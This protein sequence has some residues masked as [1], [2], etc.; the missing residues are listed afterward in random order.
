MLFVG[1]RGAAGGL[2]FRKGKNKMNRLLSATVVCAAL[3]LLPYLRAETGEGA[4]A[5]EG[6][7]WTLSEGIL[8]KEGWQFPAE[9]LAAQK[10][11]YIAGYTA[12]QGVL[13]WDG[14]VLRMGKERAGSA[15]SSVEGME[16]A[17][18]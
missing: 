2:E 1:A 9:W 18:E 8:S 5:G 3:G 11:L 15:S 12:G 7:V 17:K 14:F 16:K 4:S 6:N 10:I 13:D